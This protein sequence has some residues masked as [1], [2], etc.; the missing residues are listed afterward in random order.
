M[1]NIYRPYYLRSK[2][3]LLRK[4]HVKNLNQTMKKLFLNLS[5]TN[6]IL[7]AIFGLFTAVATSYTFIKTWKTK[8]IAGNWQLSFL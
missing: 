2:T 4:I 1:F 7:A 5:K 8:D 3:S 6:K